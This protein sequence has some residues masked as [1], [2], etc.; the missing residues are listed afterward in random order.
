MEAAT[1]VVHLAAK[2]AV[3]V[4]ANY[5]MPKSGRLIPMPD[6]EPELEPADKSAADEEPPEEEAPARTEVVL[7]F[8]EPNRTLQLQ[9]L[10]ELS[11]LLLEPR[12][13]INLLFSA[14]LEGIFRGVGMDR[15]LFALL[16]RDRSQLRG[17]S[18]LGWAK[19]S[20]VRDFSASTKPIPPNIFSYA[21]DTQEP[22]WVTDNPHPSTARLLTP[23]VRSLNDSAPFFIMSLSPR[24]QSIGLIYADRQPSG[25]ELDE[26]SFTSFTFF[27]RQANL[28]L[29]TISK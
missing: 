16:T 5:G 20:A 2:D 17:R 11:S 15:V 6:D 28:C 1:K 19:E 29:S 14:L 7:E 23:E 18:G 27:G 4:A 26:E 24:G 3:R 9:V 25:R 8:P 12:I 13:D 22:L 10:H 21:L